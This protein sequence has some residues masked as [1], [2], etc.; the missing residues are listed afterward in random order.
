[1]SDE[2]DYIIFDNLLDGIDASIFS[3]ELLFKNQHRA[4]LKYYIERWGNAIREHEGFE[5]NDG[6]SK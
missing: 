3:G 5:L 1:M 4:L 2:T 6:A